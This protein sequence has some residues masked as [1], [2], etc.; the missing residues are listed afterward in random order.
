MSELDQG[1]P[2]SSRTVAREPWI[3]TTAEGYRDSSL[4]VGMTI[5]S[6]FSRRW[7]VGLS[8]QPSIVISTAPLSFRTKRENPAAWPRRN[9]P[10]GD[11]TRDPSLFPSIE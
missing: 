3:A 7:F 5:G 2:M 10:P 9:V 11:G 6:C 1:R 8:H 4:R